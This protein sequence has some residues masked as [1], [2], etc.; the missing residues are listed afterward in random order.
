MVFLYKLVFDHILVNKSKGAWLNLIILFAL[1]QAVLTKD[2]ANYLDYTKK[3]KETSH[4]EAVKN[5]LKWTESQ[6]E[7]LDQSPNRALAWTQR[8]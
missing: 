4:G 6:F 7:E 3:E 1:L 2:F 5:Y 8:I